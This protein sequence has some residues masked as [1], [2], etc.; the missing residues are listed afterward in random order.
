MI[1]TG[2]KMD[3]NFV[4][5]IVKNGKEQE[6]K[7][8]ELL[9]K[10]AVVSAHMSNNSSSCDRQALALSD[11]FGWFQKKGYNVISVSKDSVRAHKNYTKKYGI[12]HTLVADPEQK[13]A[14]ATDTIIEKN[15]FG[16]TF[17]D[18]SRSAFVIDTDGTILASIQK[19]N[20]KEHAQELKTL[21]N[22]LN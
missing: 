20:T 9:D 5:H 3:T 13:F 17:T 1:E 16:R 2:S 4:V 11:N 10:P 21:V 8:S 19:V 15:M 7:F 14:E 6:V 22:D 12:K 18:P